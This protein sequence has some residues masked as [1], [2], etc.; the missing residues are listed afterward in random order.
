MELS[1]LGLFDDA[2]ID[3]IDA[4]ICLALADRP[5]ADP[6]PLRQMVAGWTMRLQADQQPVSG[7]GRARRLAALVAGESGITGAVR[8]YDNPLNADLMA[9]AERERGLPVALSILY[10]ALARRVGWRAAA[11]GLPGHV[12]VE[13]RGSGEPAIIDPF[14]HG[15][16]I[17]RARIEEIARAGGADSL[18]SRLAELSNRQLLVRMLANQ[19]TR[20][21]AAGDK[22]RAL[23]LHVRMTDIAPRFSGLWWERARLEQLLGRNAAARASLTAMLETTRDPDMT[24]RIRTALASVARSES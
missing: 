1:D 12:V 22:L 4:G 6:T 2:D 11:L 21:Q 8:D 7:Q 19:A 15:H 24:S 9:V 10:V 17:D 18:P 20:A 16:G 14:D 13:V 5:N 23:V 3:L